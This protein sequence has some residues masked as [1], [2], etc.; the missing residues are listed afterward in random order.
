MKE[1]RI[2]KILPGWLSSGATVPSIIKEIKG[3]GSATES[4]LPLKAETEKLR[5]GG[6]SHGD[7]NDGTERRRARGLDLSTLGPS[8]KGVDARNERDNLERKGQ[9]KGLAESERKLIEKA[10]I[11]DRLME[12]QTVHAED[13]ERYEV[14]FLLKKKSSSHK[15]KRGPEE[16]EDW[17]RPIDTTGLALGSGAMMSEDTARERERRAWEEGQGGERERRERNQRKVFKEDV[18]MIHEEVEEERDRAERIK[19]RK[20]EEKGAK[21]ELAKRKILQEKLAKLKGGGKG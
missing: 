16:E 1:E 20:D 2:S 21:L 3:L 15:R 8:N 11:Y 13:D 10:K 17:R 14:D 5:S 7:V 12:G 4:L 6:V 18:R 19:S 9:Q